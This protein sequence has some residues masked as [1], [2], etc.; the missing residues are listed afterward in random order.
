MLGGPA[1]TFTQRLPTEIE[2]LE[3]ITM[4]RLVCGLAI[5]VSACGG[6][7]DSS[8]TATPS[9][10]TPTTAAS[11]ESFSGTVSVAGNDFHPFTVAT[12]GATLSVTLTAA[13][14]PSTIF[15]GLG[16]GV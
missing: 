2:P 12:A 6:N 11:T 10:P 7:S 5:V 15:V 8:T 16:L 14:P 1:N 9:A 4:R 3:R 13:G